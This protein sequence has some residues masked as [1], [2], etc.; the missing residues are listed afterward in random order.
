MSNAT[1]GIGSLLA[2]ETSAGSGSFAVIAE[3]KSISGPDEKRAI[4]DVTNHSSA[5]QTREY[6]NGLR[7]TGSLKF[8]VNYL[9]GDTTQNGTTG[10][11]A[12]FL[13]G[14]KWNYK[15]TLPDTRVT[16]ITFSA[17]CIS[18]SKMFPIDKE[19]SADIELKLTGPVTI[20]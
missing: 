15:L 18:H 4:V 9:P 2:L 20:S 6:I 17:I 19:F 12:Q 11:Y 5:N 14:T 16:V 8:Q 3:V 1:L 10:I 13:N 7:D